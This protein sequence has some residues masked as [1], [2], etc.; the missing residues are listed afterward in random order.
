MFAYSNPPPPPRQEKIND[1][2]YYPASGLFPLISDV[3]R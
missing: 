2:I 3:K 1:G